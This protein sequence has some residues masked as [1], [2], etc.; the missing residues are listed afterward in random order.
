MCVNGIL[1]CAFDISQNYRHLNEPPVYNFV[2]S[3]QNPITWNDYCKYGVEHGARMP[4]M[5]SIWYW[6]FHM[7]PSR[8]LVSILT[9]L[10][11]ILPAL[12]IDTGLVIMQRKPKMLQVYRKIHRF[13]DVI[14]Y[15]TNGQWYFT[16]QNVQQLW[17][18][19]TPQD[20]QLFFFNMA[21][22]NW[23]EVISMSIFGIRTYLMKEDPNNIP[24]A[25]KRTQRLKI[26]HFATIYTIYTAI[27]YF[28]YVL[29]SKFFLPLL[30]ATNQI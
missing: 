11:H 25:L 12:L 17:N 22:L 3:S 27:L 4:M 10:Y 14:Y 9:F 16:N 6:S 30:S 2:A 18:K 7:S 20:Q 8:F 19:L 28:V 24:E 23:S 26:L 5:K 15:F 1:A 13:C 29:L 21:E